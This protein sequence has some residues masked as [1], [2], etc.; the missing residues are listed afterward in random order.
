MKVAVHERRRL[1]EM[2]RSLL[3]L[4]PPDEKVADRLVELPGIGVEP[5]TFLELGERFLVAAFHLEPS[6][7]CAMGFG[8]RRVD[9]ER[10]VRGRDTVVDLVAEAV[11][12][13]GL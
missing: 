13:V 9:R 4:A 12:K 1:F 6:G 7:H 2:R 10:G 3:N 8:D 5:K 11:A